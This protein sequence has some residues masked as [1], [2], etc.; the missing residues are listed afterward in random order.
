LSFDTVCTQNGRFSYLIDEHIGVARHTMLKNLI[1]YYLKGRFGVTSLKFVVNSKRVI[2]NL[3]GMLLI[4]GCLL[5]YGSLN[6]DLNLA[7]YLAY[8]VVLAIAAWLLVLSDHVYDHREIDEN[9]EVV[10]QRELAL[11][12]VDKDLG[13]SKNKGNSKSENKAED[14]RK[15]ISKRM[16]L[17]LEKMELLICELRRW[18]TLDELDLE[19]KLKEFE[20]IPRDEVSMYRVSALSNIELGKTLLSI[21]R[22]YESNVKILSDVLSSL[23]W[24]VRRYELQC[25]N[26]IFKLF[27]ENKNNRKLK[28][29]VPIHLPLLP[30][31]ESYNEKWDFIMSIPNFFPKKNS[32]DLFYDEV[33]RRI[34]EIPIQLVEDVKIF[35]DKRLNNEKIHPVIKN[36]CKE[37]IETLR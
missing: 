33:K 16:R 27:L 22:K 7:N 13:D 4:I 32:Q 18:E 29:V 25:T 19:A 24:M 11:D 36:Q 28:L 10:A 15:T 6:S 1:L 8:G 26:E 17:K 2:L 9:T 14:I 35:L 21:G 23:G 5:H 34:D 30:Q 20:K 31:F 3:F 37:L 12:V